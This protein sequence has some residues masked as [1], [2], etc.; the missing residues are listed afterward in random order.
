[1]NQSPAVSELGLY[2]LAL[3]LASIGGANAIIPDMH[4]HFVELR[5]WMTG[6]EFVELVALAQAA[7]GPNV[8]IVTLLGWRI[9]GL[10][11][12]LTATLAICLPSSLLAYTFAHFWQRFR[13]ARWQSVV[14]DGLAPITV[15]LVLAGGYV[16]AQ[17]AD[18]SWSAYAI[19]AATV[20]VVLVT[21]LHPLWL[22]GTAGLIGFF[23]LV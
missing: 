12:A 16:L 21:K 17:T 15:G 9:N 7:P 10:A 18:R 6:T 14:R 2:F 13:H 8:L 4:R 1:M 5:G 11:G 23:G 3:S 19:T 20:V 22:L